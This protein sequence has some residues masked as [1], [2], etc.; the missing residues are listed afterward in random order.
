MVELGDLAV[1]GSLGYIAELAV[2][3]VLSVRQL[4]PID[5]PILHFHRHRVAF[6][7]VKQLDG[8]TLR[9]KPTRSTTT[10][11]SAPSVAQVAMQH[12]HDRPC[13]VTSQYVIH[14]TANFVPSNSV[15]RACHGTQRKSSCETV[16]P[17]YNVPSKSSSS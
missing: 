6:A 1:F 2:H 10:T 12:S 16:P 3:A 13:S 17:G 5:F 15:T 7:F 14:K 9:L 11:P 8:N 4:T